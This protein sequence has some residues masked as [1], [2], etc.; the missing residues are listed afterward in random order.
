MNLSQN[1]KLNKPKCDQEE[2]QIDISLENKE[3]SMNAEKQ[4][5]Y[6]IFFSSS[7]FNRNQKSEFFF[8]KFFNFLFYQDNTIVFFLFS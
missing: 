2:A 3:P 1:K 7:R 5:Y 6:N 8:R 4:I